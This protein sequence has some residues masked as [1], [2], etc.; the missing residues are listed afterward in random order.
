MYF[1]AKIKEK[2]RLYG[3]LL[4][5]VNECEI[6]MRYTKPPIDEILGRCESYAETALIDTVKSY[7]RRVA[8][9]LPDTEYYC[10]L[11][12]LTLDERQ[13][14]NDFFDGLGKTSAEG[15]EKHLL[16]FNERFT[17]RYNEAREREVKCGGSFIKLGLSGGIFICI[18]LL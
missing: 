12:G 10:S 15:Q 14:I 18:L 7:C 3:D 6:Y 13:E 5:L 16:L 2:R 8:F 1:A 4:R 11:D 17:A 9:G